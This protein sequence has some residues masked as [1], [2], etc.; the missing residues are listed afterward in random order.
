MNPVNPLLARFA[1]WRKRR[2]AQRGLSQRVRARFDLR[3][4]LL[5]VGGALAVCAL[6]LVARAVDLQLVRND[7]YRA[8]GDERF[9]REIRIPTSRGMITDR[10]GEPL[11]VSTP[12]ESIGATPREVL[13][14]PARLP[15]LAAALDT[16]VESLTRKLTQRMDRDFVY[17]KRRLNPAEARRILALGIPGVRSEREYRRY[18]PQGE[19]IAHVL[20]FTNIDDRGQEGLELAFD[21]Q[22]AGRPGA[23]RVIQIVAAAWSRKS[24]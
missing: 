2:N 12:V 23:K 21:E 17:L 1:D 15:A 14:E 4:R 19:A 5:L 6:A 7:F 24:I 11:A 8:Q 10:N 13:A 18:Y 16:D 20:G 3:G 22:L 9:V